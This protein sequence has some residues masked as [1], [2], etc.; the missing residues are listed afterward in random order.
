MALGGPL[1]GMQLLVVQHA[2]EREIAFQRPALAVGVPRVPGLDDLA[3][4]PGGARVVDRDVDHE[5]VAPRRAA[6]L[7]ELL[8]DPVAAEAHQH[9][10]RGGDEAPAIA[11]YE[12]DV[13]V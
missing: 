3:E 9:A 4:P 6:L 12:S 11:V 1:L 2:I 8:L 5:D 10:V 13:L 7:A